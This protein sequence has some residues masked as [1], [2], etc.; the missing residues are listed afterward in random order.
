MLKTLISLLTNWN[1]LKEWRRSF[2]RVFSIFALIMF[3]LVNVFNPSFLNLSTANAVVNGL[4]IDPPT[5]SYT[6]SMDFGMQRDADSSYTAGDQVNIQISAYHCRTSGGADCAPDLAAGDYFERVDFNRTVTVPATGNNTSFNQGGFPAWNCGRVQVDVGGDGIFGAAKYDLGSNCPGDNPGNPGNP[7]PCP[8]GAADAPGA[9]TLKAP[10][11]QPQPDG[12]TKVI[13]DWDYTARAHTYDFRLD[14]PRTPASPDIVQDNIGTDQTEHFLQDKGV[15]YNWW[16]HAKNPCGVSPAS[17]SS[18]EIPAA[19]QPVPCTP[20]KPGAPAVR[21]I[22]DGV[23]WNAVDRAAIYNVRLVQ[24]GGSANSPK[25]YQG[26]TNT[27]FHFPSSDISAPG[28]YTGWVDAAN[29]CGATGGAF[30]FT[31]QSTP[32]GGGNPTSPQP[33]CGNIVVSPTSVNLSNNVD[34]NFNGAIN[35]PPAN[36]TYRWDFGDNTSSNSQNTTHRYSNAGTYSPILR[37]LV[38]GAIVLSCPGAVVAVSPAGGNPGELTLTKTPV[39]RI[40]QAGDEATFTITLTNN[41]GSAIDNITVTDTLPAG[42]TYMS[43]SI[44]PTSRESV[45]EDDGRILKWTNVSVPSGESWST[46]LRVDTPLPFFHSS[47]PIDTYTNRVIASKPGR[48]DLLAEARINIPG[49]GTVTGQGSLRNE[50]FVVFTAC[51]RDEHTT[52]IGDC[53]KFGVGE[54]I[55]FRI[56]VINTSNVTLRNVTVQ[57]NVPVNLDLLDTNLTH[58]ATS[59][60]G[61]QVIW[62]LG[63]IGSGDSRTIEFTTTVRSDIPAADLTSVTNTVQSNGINPSGNIVSA[64]PTTATAY[65]SKPTA[66]GPDILVEKTPKTQIVASSGSEA[67]FTIKI[68]NRT[69]RDLAGVSVVDTL[70]NELSFVDTVSVT[71]GTAAP[72]KSNGDKTLTWSGISLAVNGTWTVTFRAR[73]TGNPGTTYTNQAKASA[74]NRD[75]GPDIATVTIS[76]SGIA[77]QGSGPVNVFITMPGQPGIA[78]VR[79]LPKTGLPIAVWAVAAFIPAGLRIR[80]FSRNHRSDTKESAQYIW[81]VKQY[82]SKAF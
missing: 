40:V 18:F 7:G 15:T 45:G 71:S 59:V 20:E 48:V 11:F 78:A 33:S 4:H 77:S 43:S 58:T 66:G 10:V 1:F 5:G 61:R 67:T 73:V 21:P 29:D 75:F 28:T 49:G 76:Q 6:N 53:K 23:E 36:A 17:N 3:L 46:V 68:T 19:P 9:V 65:V 54:T 80:K 37:V 32:P 38:G 56:K 41:T 34:I 44:N 81:E 63:T 74:D 50:K 24:P 39:D 35:N 60:S 52:L 14:D 8:N 62:N 27:W 51:G 42:L 25:A 22:Q 13:F 69:G 26:T 47:N 72:T 16:V 79:S 64:S 82:K 31:V 57:D 70:P 2:L 55:K 30:S 12:R